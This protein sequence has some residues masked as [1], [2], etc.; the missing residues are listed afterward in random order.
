[1]KLK[2][3]RQPLS[4]S[5]HAN[6][7]LVLKIE[8]S[9]IQFYWTLKSILAFISVLFVRI[10][11]NNNTL[12]ACKLVVTQSWAM[13]TVTPPECRNLLG[14][15]SL[16]TRDTRHLV[17][18]H[19]NHARA[20]AWIPALFIYRMSKIPTTVYSNNYCPKHTSRCDLQVIG[21]TLLEPLFNTHWKRLH[22]VTIKA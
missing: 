1:M 3:V 20:L 6:N 22:C 9:K 13:C 10:Y 2:V 14:S 7:S 18:D 19:V 4:C 5:R 11:W 8:L 12:F 17:H 21:C 16:I 15:A